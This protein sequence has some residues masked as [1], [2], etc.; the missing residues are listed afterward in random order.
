[1]NLTIF[2]IICC[3]ILIFGNI[4]YYLHWKYKWELPSKETDNF[5]KKRKEVISFIERDRKEYEQS[6][7]K[8]ITDEINKRKQEL[9]Q[10]Q[11]F[12]K[13]Q[14]DQLLEDYER[15]KAKVNEKI[16]SLQVKLNE[17]I[18]KQAKI[19]AESIQ[20]TMDYYAQERANI[21][22]DFINF[23]NEIQD[24]I[25]ALQEDLRKEEK[26][27]QEIIEEYKRAEQIKQNKDFYRIV[28]SEN[29]QSDV[30]KLRHIADELHDPSVLY[31]LIY[32]TYYERPFNE[33]VG[34]V[35]TGRGSIGIYK[36]TNLENGRVYIGQT[37]QAFKDR[38]RTHLKRGVKAEPGTQNKLYNAM[39]EEGVEN[40]TFEVLAECSTDE[41]NR[42]EKEFISL[43][44]ADT[45][46]YNATSGNN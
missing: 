40:F 6:E 23:K 30:I 41:L 24:K 28:L 18:E 45:W 16:D 32:K 20:S 1:M 42:K 37:R 9:D 21:D 11:C 44:H 38:W 22:I 26:R 15:K 3:V 34:R 2:L 12:F 36:I 14:E 33:M 35:I 25:A 17:A 4:G 13:Q 29:A 43:Y 10:K 7:I 39:W 46:G 5:K 31:K 19:E 8:K 27:Q